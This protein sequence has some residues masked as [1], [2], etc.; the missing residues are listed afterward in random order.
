MSVLLHISDTHFGTEQSPVLDALCEL[1]RNLRPEVIVL[2]GDI[3]QRARRSQFSAARRFLDRLMPA[4][5]LAIPGNHDIPL[6]NLVAR[7]L[8]PYANYSRAFGA[9]LEPHHDSESFLILSANTTRPKHHKDGEISTRQIQRIAECLRHARSEQLR[10][11]VTHQPILVT[12]ASDVKNLLQ[13]HAEAVRTWAEAGADLVLGGHIHLPYVR[14]AGD[15][16]APRTLWAV[17]AGTAVS[18]R[19]RDNIPNSVNIVRHDGIRLACSVERW[20]YDHGTSAFGC[21]ATQSLRL[22]RRE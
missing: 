10:V 20:D 11:V 4:S 5:L 2:S 1:S 12:R 19:T 8:Y 15:G 22:D 21:V 7:L 9:D 3:T 16:A 6:F 13:G 18:S 14:S 17:Q